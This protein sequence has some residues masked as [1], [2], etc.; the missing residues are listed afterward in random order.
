MRLGGLAPLAGAGIALGFGLFFFDQFCGALGEAN[1]IPPFA[2]AW[3]PP[4]LA[5]L[6]GFTLLSYTE[7]G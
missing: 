7:D 2:A 1:A 4:I 5:L 6:S 3:T